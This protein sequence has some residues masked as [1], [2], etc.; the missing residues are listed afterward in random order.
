MKI[1]CN[2]IDGLCAYPQSAELII[3]CFLP[4]CSGYPVYEV[5]SGVYS[6]EQI[7][8]ILLSPH[9]N[10]KKICHSKPI[11]VNH[12]STF[13]VDLDCLKH[14]DDIKKDDFGKWIYSGSHSVS[15]AAFRAGGRLDFERLS[16]VPALKADNVFQ[17]RRINCKHPLNSQC[18]RLL[19]FVT[20]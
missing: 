20:G 12:S 1:N 11:N 8:K 2:L 10:K 3:F 4:F 19:A 17:L 16:G 13:V 7:L 15:Y 6:G 9:L 5:P 18:Q 14:P